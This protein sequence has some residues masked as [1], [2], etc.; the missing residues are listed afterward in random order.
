MEGSGLWLCLKIKS[1][2]FGRNHQWPTNKH[3]R[4][5][6]KTHQWMTGGT[7]AT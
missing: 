1:P 6:S 3:R 7:P 4:W 2:N 5:A